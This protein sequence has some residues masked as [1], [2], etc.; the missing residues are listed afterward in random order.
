M[1]YSWKS[2]SSS[3]NCLYGHTKLWELASIRIRLSSIGRH[4]TSCLQPQ[5]LVVALYTLPDN[6]IQ[7]SC[8]HVYLVQLPFHLRSEIYNGSDRSVSGHRSECLFIVNA[9]LLGKAM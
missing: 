9:F 7:E 1:L 5:I 4:E 3:R 8:L 2:P 6:T